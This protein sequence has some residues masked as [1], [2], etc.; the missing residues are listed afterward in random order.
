[1]SGGALQNVRVRAAAESSGSR[2]GSTKRLAGPDC[3]NLKRA[4]F[5][6]CDMNDTW[7]AGLRGMIIIDSKSTRY[8]VQRE[9]ASEGV[10]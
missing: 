6:H 5:G 3:R 1:M 8:D 4:G 10:P 7:S 9:A 2:R